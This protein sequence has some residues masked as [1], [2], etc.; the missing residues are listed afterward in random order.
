VNEYNQKKNGCECELVKDDVRVSKVSM[1]EDNSIDA[2]VQHAL[3]MIKQYVIK[4]YKLYGITF[5]F[6][7][8]FFESL[9]KTILKNTFS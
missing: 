9:M 4:L 6:F 2:K 7:H 1:I 5:L 3:V 8:L